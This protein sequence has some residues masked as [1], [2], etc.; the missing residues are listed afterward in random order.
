MDDAV[1][2]RD[3]LTQGVAAGL[4][5]P[6]HE[7]RASRA[8]EAGPSPNGARTLAELIGRADIRLEAPVSR[9]E[10]GLPIGNGAM[11]TLI[12][13]SPTALH[14]QINRCD[15]FG[16]GAATLSFPERDTD[17]AGG[18][19]FV[20]LDLGGAG[21]DVFTAG[22]MRQHLALHTGELRLNGAGVRVRALAWP[23]QDVIALE[24]E[25]QRSRPQPVAIELRMLRY[26][27][28]YLPGQN[29]A[30]AQAGVVEVRHR[31]QSAASQLEIRGR[32]AILSQRFREGKFYSASAVAACILGRPA[33]ARR[34]SD[35]AVRVAGEAGRGTF[36][37]LIAS[38]ASFDPKADVAALALKK[39]AAARR[40]GGPGIAQD[41]RVWWRAYWRRGW[42]A[43]HSAD[44]AAEEVERNYTY[45]LYLMA[46]CSRGAYMPRF[47]GLLFM[48]DGDLR[49]WGSQYWWSNQACYYDGLMQANRRELLQP[50]FNTYTAMAPA[51]HRAAEQQWGSRGIWIPET[52]WFDGE[53]ELPEEIAA[54]MREIWLA[55]K[56]WRE[57][58]RAFDV[59][60]WPKQSGNSR[61]NYKAKG[62]YEA[63]RYVWRSKGHGCFGHTSHILSSGAKIAWQYWLRYAYTRDL[64]WLRDHAFP[65]LAGMA[66]LYR[67]FPN[68]RR[69]A[70]G[71]YHIHH[72]NCSE[73]VWDAQDTHEELCAMRGL[74][75]LAIRASELLGE[76]V[77]QRAQWRELL[78]HLAPLVTNRDLP[79]E[80]PEAEFKPP[81]WVAARPP[82]GHGNVAAPWLLPALYYDLCTANSTDAAVRQLAEATYTR[83]Y[84]QGVNTATPISELNPY[85]SAAAHLGRAEDLRHMLLNQIR[86]LD[87]GHDFC[88]W[89]GSGKQT[90]VMEN[91]M[92]L[93]EGPGDVGAER[94][95]RMARALHLALLQS[96]PPRP[97]EEPALRLF[98]AWPAT[99]DARFQ[100]LAQGGVLV[101]ASRRGGRTGSV[102]LRAQAAGPVRLRN[103]WPGE[104]VILRQAGRPERR[105]R[106]AWLEFE[107]HPG[108]RVILRAG[109]G[110]R[111]KKT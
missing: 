65:M 40:R 111:E 78:A 90:V 24:V 102:R 26:R 13:T 39:L 31:N 73:P 82:A 46:A 63:G 84:P 77:K 101:T 27:H 85:A 87:P 44:G 56:P 58:S 23:R 29:D 68:L 93:R 35:A 50:V 11:G 3:F 76:D 42:I 16:A 83:L 1:T 10:A 28:Q 94:L 70:D 81:Y 108:D 67:N 64:Q 18:C 69:G 22:A 8:G 49:M 110:R 30:L 48:T 95:G 36:T 17:Y 4:A 62:R 41:N 14:M 54:E 53:E 89:K 96:A 80:F 9:P 57:R 12:W 51:L 25:D 61:W 88:D 33:R 79:A 19:G 86:C 15:V 32:T 21:E 7:R 43:L 75:P 99:W 104:A 105:M 100:L 45:F 98:P 92:T 107:L 34:A 37:V 52:T 55:R 91:R 47:G 103:P 71:H 72:V 106:G 60:A 97:G 74:L 109:G 66:E 6:G 59:Y 2:R 20:D 38:A 5:W